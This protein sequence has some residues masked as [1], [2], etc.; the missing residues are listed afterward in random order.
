MT[1]YNDFIGAE[2][3][4]FWDGISRTFTRPTST[5]GTIT[6]NKVG[7]TVNILEVYGN[8]DVYTDATLSEA[9]TQ[10]G[11]RN[12]AIVFSPGTWTISN[13]V[14]IPSNINV[15]IPN[16][17]S[18]Q[19][20]T[21]KTLTINGGISA[22]FYQIFGGAGSIVLGQSA[23]YQVYPHWW[24][25]K[26][27]GT[28]DD[29]TPIQSASNSLTTG[30][31]MFFPTST[32]LI[33][34]E[35]TI[36][37]NNIVWTGVGKASKILCNTGSTD[38][39]VNIVSALSKSG[40]VIEKLYFQNSGY[41]D[42][43]PAS[44]TFTTMGCGVIFKNCT[45]SIVRDC[46]FYKCGGHGQGVTAIYFSSSKRCTAQG[47]TIT[48]C[49]NGVNSDNWYRN[50]DS[51]A[52]SV[53]NNIIGNTI[54]TTY[55]QPIIVD[56]N[57]GDT[58]GEEVGD[59]IV[60]NILY[61]NK[62]GIGV[63]GQKVN[64][65]GNH[66]DMNNYS[67]GGVGWDGIYV[68]GNFI[69]ISNNIITNAYRSGIMIYA[70]NSNG[71]A[72]AGY[73]IGGLAARDIVVTGNTIKWDTGIGSGD[74]GGSQGIR[75]KNGNTTSAVARI[76]ITDNQI[77]QARNYG[78]LLDGTT[79]SLGDCIVKNNRVYTSGD[80]GIRAGGIYDNSLN[81]E[82]N[83]VLVCTN[84]G[85]EVSSAPKCRVLNNLATACTKHGIIVDQSTRSQIAFNTA[86]DNGSAA[87]GTY[88]GIYISGGSTLCTIMGNCSGNLTTVNQVYGIAIEDVTSG[89]RC[90]IIA[91]TYTTNVTGNFY[92]AVLY[93][94]TRF[95][96]GEVGQQIKYGSA[97]P[98]TGTWAA[99][100]IVNNTAPTAGGFAGW[101]C[102]TGGA[103]GTWKTF[104]AISA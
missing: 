87:P 65:T 66:I 6:M 100:D 30:G 64:I 32:Y 43:T 74:A 11:S 37:Y 101:I 55:G 49:L 98:T 25:A 44:G 20:A 16:G 83:H 77:Y 18:I 70:N 33:T 69:N 52:R 14:T 88:A 47:N 8:G 58:F 85:I 79:Q 91:N 78:I 63:V 46:Y 93:G 96:E 38:N 103:P 21:T 34:A 26:G 29:T 80:S 40:V 23:A 99:G 67:Y 28:T 12:V 102:V 72:V 95:L 59:N 81:I 22:G 17:A 84:Y 90:L 48:E 9:I 76:T 82:G 31:N 75:V 41:G 60:G 24:G 39:G 94:N 45:D 35:I 42:T 7:E 51:A 71:A 4:K 27:D 50:V 57:G 3:I 61:N 54:Y 89:G 19:P 36:G 73:P 56:I 53:M 68:T 1:T 92:E 13:N 15:I 10:I 2:D 5:G 86:R 104:G 62:Y 97:A